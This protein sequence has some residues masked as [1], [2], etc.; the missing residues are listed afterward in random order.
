MRAPR[1]AAC[2]EHLIGDAVALA[3][4][5]RLFLAG[6]AQAHLLAHVAGRGPAHQRLDLARLLGLEIEHPGLGL[7]EARLHGGLGR[8]VDACGHDA[9]P[10]WLDCVKRHRIK[11]KPAG[12]QCAKRRNLCVRY[13]QARQKPCEDGNV[14]SSRG[15]ACQSANRDNEKT[16]ADF[17]PEGS[18]LCQLRR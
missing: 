1:T 2:L 7:G 14:G 8:L 18:V 9:M 13:A 5:D 15:S 16:P 4:G 11:A 3:I 10:I 12:W 6:K 17:P